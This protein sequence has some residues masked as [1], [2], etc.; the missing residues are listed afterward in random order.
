AHWQDEGYRCCV[1]I[2]QKYFVKFDDYETLWPQV[3]MQ[4]HVYWYAESDTSAPCVPKLLHFFKSEGMGYTV[5]EYINLTFPPFLAEKVAENLNW[6]SRVAAPP[7][8][9]RTGPLGNGC[10][11]HSLFKDFT[12][13]LSFSSIEALQ[14]YLN[15]V[16][17]C[18]YFLEYLCLCL[19]PPVEPLRISD[20]LLIFTQSN[21]DLSNFGVDNE[22][23]TVLLDFSNVGLLKQSSVVRD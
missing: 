4:V 13:P 19:V 20:K 15:K 6:L 2:K 22:G 17:P 16:C 5:M 21:M 9:V 1:V 12:V 14:Q 18:L 23:K 10:A 3:E 7:D 8:H 11:C